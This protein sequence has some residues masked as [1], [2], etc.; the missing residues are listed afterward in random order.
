VRILFSSYTCKSDS[1]SESQTSFEILVSTLELGHYVAII[2]QDKHTTD[3]LRQIP[4]RY[5]ENLK[6][7][8]ILPKKI[9]GSKYFNSWKFL[10]YINYLFFQNQV[11]RILIDLSRKDYDY[12][13]HT[14]FGNIWLPIGIRNSSIPSILGPIGGL[15]RIPLSMWRFLGMR[16]ISEEIAHRLLARMGFLLFGKRTLRKASLVIS[17]NHFDKTIFSKFAKNSTVLSHP[18]INQVAEKFSKSELSSRNLVVY[19]GRFVAWK[20]LAILLKS[21]SLLPEDFELI[22]IGSGPDFHRLKRLAQKYGVAHRVQF[23]G[24]LTRQQVLNHLSNARVVVNPSLR[25]SS[26]WLIAEAIALAK[27]VAGF[28]LNGVGSVLKIS[29][30]QGVEYR[31][32]PVRNLATDIMNSSNYGNAENFS[33]QNLTDFLSRIYV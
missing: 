18:I 4:M 2:T 32:S 23:P 25:D 21:I 1:G 22:L 12:V 8:G 14:S 26:G 9:I 15:G 13:H 30:L 3:I 24:K 5:H 31:N 20:G 29:G 6:I 11:R 10:T 7:I 17:A 16:G 33:K 27:P 28:D 19:A